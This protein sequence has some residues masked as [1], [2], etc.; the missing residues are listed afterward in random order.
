MRTTISAR[1]R[2]HNKRPES[3]IAQMDWANI[4]RSVVFPFVEVIDSHYND[5]MADAVAKY[6]DRLIGFAA[7]NP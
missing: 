7:V 1:A 5:W 4:D 2:W 3:L 6:P